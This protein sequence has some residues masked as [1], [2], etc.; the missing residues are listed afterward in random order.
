[1]MLVTL[2]FAAN[3]FGFFTI[4]LSSPLMTRLAGRSVGHF[5]QGILATLLATPCSAP[6]MGTALALLWRPRWPSCGWSFWRWGSE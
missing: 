3:L 6:F 5:W 4:T 2:L 1:M